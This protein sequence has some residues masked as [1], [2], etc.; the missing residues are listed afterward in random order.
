MAP[1]STGEYKMS[2]LKDTIRE[3]KIA[4]KEFTPATVRMPKE[5]HSVIEALGDH[6]S[7]SKQEVLL[8]LIKEGIKVADDELGVNEP[9]TEAS[10]ASVNFHVLNTNKRH[11]V[12]DQEEMMSGGIAAAFY[13]PWKNNIDRIEKGDTIFLYENGV[14]IVAYGKG[15]G[16]TLMKNRYD[17]IDECHY[18]ELED[19]KVLETP[20]PA[21]AIKKVLGRNVVF[22]KTMSGMPD[23][24]KILD[25]INEE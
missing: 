24:Q 18:Q 4:K 25:R 9:E 13:T 3:S 15:S 1:T 21:A 22:L 10:T 23:G 16:K 2:D 20:L 6:L 7:R 14:G 11:D 12:D 19:F 8:M 5:M 17:D